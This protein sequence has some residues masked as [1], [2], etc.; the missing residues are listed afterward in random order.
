MMTIMTVITVIRTLARTDKV[1]LKNPIIMSTKYVKM[2]RHVLILK[3][4]LITITHP[5]VS[6]T[7][8]SQPESF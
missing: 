6:E 4:R 3:K 7:L 2:T 5:S 1:P 8:G